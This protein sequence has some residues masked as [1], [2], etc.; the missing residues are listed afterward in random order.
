MDQLELTIRNGIVATASETMR[1]DI[2]VAGEKI[3]AMAAHRLEAAPEA[4]V[5]RVV[6]LGPSRWSARQLLHAAEDEDE[7]GASRSALDDARDLLDL[8]A[9]E[10]AAAL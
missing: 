5:A 6:W 10:A 1:C 9:P 2:G 3:V 7:P 4:D 8:L